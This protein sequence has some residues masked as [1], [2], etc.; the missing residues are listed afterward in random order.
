MSPY[1]KSLAT[2]ERMSKYLTELVEARTTV[3]FFIHNPR[4]LAYR[5]REAMYA[6]QFHQ[7]FQH[8]ARLKSS[9]KF[10]VYGD[11]VRARWMEI[12]SPQVRIIVERVSEGQTTSPDS[13]ADLFGRHIREALT[14][15]D[16]PNV[17][18]F[19]EVLGAAM[20]YLGANPEVY[21]PNV[22]LDNSELR[23]LFT[24]AKAK[25]LK[26]IYDPD[27]GLTITEKDIDEDIAWK[28]EGV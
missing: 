4:S 18:N 1:N 11:K 27:A 17:T 5:L 12:E 10:L 7:N 26:L 25:E 3:D 6:C 19:M 15:V 22:E 9:Y 21:F 13:E 14:T 23:R 16:V 28:P 20:K 2:C 24:W 8:V